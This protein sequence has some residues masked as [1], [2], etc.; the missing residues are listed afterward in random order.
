MQTRILF[1]DDEPNVLVALRRML[2]PLHREWAME[3]AEGGQQALEILERNRFD[4]IVSDMRMPGMSGAE[5]L[6]LARNRFPDMA[7]IILTGQCNKE[8]GLSALRVAHQLLDKPCD[9]RNLQATITRI[10]AL[11][12]L[13]AK[14][15]I[16][17]LI[18]M[19]PPTPTLPGILEELLTDVDTVT[20]SL[21]EVEAMMRKGLGI[22]AEAIRIATPSFFGVRRDPAEDDHGV[23]LFRLEMLRVLVL[24]VGLLSSL[25]PSAEPALSVEPLQRY[26]WSVCTLARDI[27]KME[28]ADP[29]SVNQ[30][31]IAGLLH[32]IGKLI[33][34][35][36]GGNAYA[37]FMSD[38]NNRIMSEWDFEQEMF[39][40]SHAEVGA[41][42]LSLWGLPFPIVEAVAWHHRPNRSGATDFGVLTA[43]HAAVALTPE[44][45]DGPIDFE[46]LKSIK[47]QLRWLAWHEKAMAVR[48]NERTQ[49]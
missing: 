37:N 21:D 7:R 1:V 16:P 27:A 8:S 45:G 5:L 30:A 36:S 25:Q 10:T 17:S 6:E 40:V 28:G 24:A 14:K 11:R 9:P 34:L 44:A 42:L 38:T 31:G 19:L 18:S 39:G 35:R 12:T 43:V 3:F 13:L 48:A 26:C 46:H 2:R 41:A 49:S 22:P 15:P 29:R 4:V 23:S 20:T 33:L 32:D 47:A